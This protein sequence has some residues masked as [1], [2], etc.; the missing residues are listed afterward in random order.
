M[1]YWMYHMKYSRFHAELYVVLGFL[2]HYVSISSWSVYFQKI[3][4]KHIEV[5]SEM[6]LVHPDAHF[7]GR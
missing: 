6:S 4:L 2:K 5:P 1:N 3:R 7:V